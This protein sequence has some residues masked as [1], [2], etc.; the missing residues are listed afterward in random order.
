[1]T[2]FNLSFTD[3][4]GV[5]HTDAVFEVVGAYYNANSAVYQD[6]A[7]STSRT[8]GYRAR[9]WPNS[10]A[11][12]SGRPPYVFVDLQ[13]RD[14]FTFSPASSLATSAEVVEAAEAHL[15]NVVLTTLVG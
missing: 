11:H 7:P 5:T 9:Y 1:M 8:A 2:M 13:G 3:A 6:G 10:A 15:R 4:Q 14:T 12:L